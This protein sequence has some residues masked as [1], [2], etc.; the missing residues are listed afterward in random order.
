MPYE[1]DGALRGRFKL[2]SLNSP[3][4]TPGGKWALFDKNVTVSFFGLFFNSF[5][6]RSHYASLGS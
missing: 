1:M 4:E 2:L 3:E 6:T 5:E